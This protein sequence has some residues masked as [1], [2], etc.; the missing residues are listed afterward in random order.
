[1]T[2]SDMVNE[3]YDW[4][5]DFI[6]NELNYTKL[7]DILFSREFTWLIYLDEN[8][9]EDGLELR[10]RF[11]ALFEYPEDF[12]KGYLSDNCTVLE[13]LIALANR[14]ETDIMY[15]PDKGDQTGYWFWLMIN[16]LNLDIYTD[17]QFDKNSKKEINKI[18]DIFLNREYKI[19]GTGNIFVIKNRKIS[20]PTT[21]IWYQLN[22]YIDE[23]F[24]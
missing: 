4:L 24:E 2:N 7:L 11:S 8:R 10:N 17:E 15:D 23:N 9:A 22:Y 3:Y 5:L 6:R 1:M 16:N 12:Y 18:L 13:M 20:V 14:C 21:E 19:D